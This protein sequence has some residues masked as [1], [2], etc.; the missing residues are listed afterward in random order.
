MK[1]E[2][3]GIQAG[4]VTGEDTVG[5]TWQDVAKWPGPI[6]DQGFASLRRGIFPLL[7]RRKAATP[8]LLAVCLEV[9]FRLLSLF[10]R[11]ET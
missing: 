4:A 2:T 1:F 7:E 11:R 6:L 5:G 8:L 10:K 3:M 9:L